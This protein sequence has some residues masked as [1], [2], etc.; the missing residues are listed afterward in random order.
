MVLLVGGVLKLK[1]CKNSSAIFPIDILL[2]VMRSEEMVS[3]PIR[4]LL[5]FTKEVFIEVK[6]DFLYKVTEAL[7]NIL[8]FCTQHELGHI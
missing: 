5:D 8:G 7:S 1:L 2:M 6:L 4:I 3:I